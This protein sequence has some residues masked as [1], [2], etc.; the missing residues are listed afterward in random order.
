M[1]L[2]PRTEGEEQLFM[3]TFQE[4]LHQKA[5]PA[6]KEGN[7]EASPPDSG[8]EAELE[9]ELVY[10]KESLKASIEEAQAA[11]EELRSA[12]EEMQSTNEEMQSTNE[13]LETSKEELQS[14][15]EELTTVNSELQSKIDQLSRAESDM[16]NLLDSTQ[17]A[18]IFLD[19]GLNI[20]RFTAP[21]TRVISLI[22]T[23]VGRPISDV[24]VKIEY[25]AIAEHAREVLDSLRP[26]EREVR[27][28]DRQWFLMRIV[29]YRTLD[30]VIDGVVLTFTDITESKRVAR[31]RAEFAENIVQT[32]REPLL[33]LDHELRVVTANKA[34][35][36]LFHVRREET[37][38]R[39][40]KD[41][42]RHEWDISVLED[43]LKDVMK[44]GKVFEDFRV[45]ADF[46]NLGHRT[47]LLNA[48]KLKAA[49]DGSGP[50]VLLAMEDISVRRTEEGKGSMEE[51]D[52]SSS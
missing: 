50:L 46:T 5:I 45:E 31:E 20:K 30:N 15:N 41:L 39:A 3:F 16:K 43:L 7:G 23:D 10:T 28:K 34:F 19:G 1:K 6:I 47:M 38:G 18:T 44:A 14:V 4:P 17:I 29:P 48:R 35:L 21:A 11:N 27:G 9:R 2:L 8:R 26:C 12:N 37:E 40:I 13:E 33:V 36:G 52:R 22:P 24:T 25:P 51:E 42:G 49:S 32:V